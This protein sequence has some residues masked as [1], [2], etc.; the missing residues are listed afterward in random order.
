[1]HDTHASNESIHSYI[2]IQCVGVPEG[3]EPTNSK[4][5]CLCSLLINYNHVNYI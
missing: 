4:G 2:I 1:M 5:V 3:I